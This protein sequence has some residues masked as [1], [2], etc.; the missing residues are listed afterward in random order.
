LVTKYLMRNIESKNVKLDVNQQIRKEK[1]KDTV[2]QD[3]NL[4][5]DEKVKRTSEIDAK[6]IN[7]C[8]LNIIEE[9]ELNLFPDSQWEMLKSL[10]GFNNELP[11]NKL[12]ITTH[13]PYIISYL[14]LAVQAASLKGRIK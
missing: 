9:P 5:S 3:M 4:S 11:E 8:L 14:S 7:S 12:I 6:Y 1:E 2:L 10:V 13:S